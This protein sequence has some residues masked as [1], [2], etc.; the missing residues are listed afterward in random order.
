MAC[1]GETVEDVGKAVAWLGDGCVAIHDD[2]FR[3]RSDMD[4][5]FVAY[6]IQTPEFESQKVNYVS[7]AKVKRLSSQSL[8]KI[9]IPTPSLD[10]QRRIVDALDKFDSLVT[11]L[12]RGLPAEI[13]ARRKQYE[14]YRDRLLTFEETNQ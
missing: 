10:Q 8:A 9:V 6:V 13:L 5:K 2:T 4:P 3:F 14:H 1:V 12:R 11:D 7:R